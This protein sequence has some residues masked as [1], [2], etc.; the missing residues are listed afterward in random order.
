[1]FV[2]KRDTQAHRHA[3][4]TNIY[5]DL[6]FL[7]NMI[8]WSQ[9]LAQIPQS[10]QG[11]PRAGPACQPSQTPNIPCPPAWT[12][13]GRFPGK[14]QPA[15]TPQGPFFVNTFYMVLHIFTWIEDFFTNLSCLLVFVFIMKYLFYVNLANNNI[16]VKFAITHFAFE[17]FFLWIN[18]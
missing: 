18:I 9:S 7:N 14:R 2:T 3:G 5:V 4:T 8:Y 11:P 12:T 15:R 6:I 13:A 17:M 16:L 10:R 1:M